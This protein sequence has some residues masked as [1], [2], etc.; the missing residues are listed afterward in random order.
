MT[1][2]AAT[3]TTG[4]TGRLCP[5]SLRRATELG[6]ECRRRAEDDRYGVRLRVPGGELGAEQAREVAAIARTAGA[7]IEVT[8]RGLLGLDGFPFDAL[9]GVVARLDAVG[10]ATRGLGPLDAVTHP[11]AGMD[12]EEL[13]DPRALAWRLAAAV[14]GGPPL[15][16][17]MIDGREVPSPECW[18]HGIALVAGRRPDGLIA[19][20]LL[21]GGA[22]GTHPRP[23]RKLP[24]WVTEG[25]VPD[26][27]RHL[28]SLAAGFEGGAGA[29]L[30]RLVGRYGAAPLL[31][32]LE[33]NL[34]FTLP[35]DSEPLASQARHEHDP[36]WFAQKQEGFWAIALGVLP[37]ALTADRLEALAALADA[38]ADGTLRTMPG[39]RLALAQIAGV[40]RPVVE[41][42]LEALGFDVLPPPPGSLPAVAG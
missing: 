20:R 11:W 25:Q 28:L 6:L 8:R 34:G 12:P 23:A 2:I 39:R 4:P 16:E 10:L 35:R 29:R 13:V 7:T 14:R 5:S 24:A 37:G 38:R 27:V 19:F 41:G 1:L 31:E 32:R 18:S 26:V 33:E 36:G 22:R 42:R 40:D 9:G 15:C 30:V 3:G 17:L 21:V